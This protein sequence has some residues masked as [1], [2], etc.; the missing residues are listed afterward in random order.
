[1][2]MAVEPSVDPRKNLRGSCG[3]AKGDFDISHAQLH[4]HGA[5]RSAEP[6]SAI[7]T[8][9]QE[10]QLCCSSCSH[11]PLNTYLQVDGVKQFTHRKINSLYGRSEDRE[12]R[13]SLK[14]KMIISYADVQGYCSLMS[15][16]EVS[17][18]ERL[19]CAI[20]DMSEL[21]SSRGGKVVDTSGDG[22]MSVFDDPSEAVK[23]AIEFQRKSFDWRNGSKHEKKMD[24][25]IGINVGNV[26]IRKNGIHGHH[27]NIAARIQEYAMPGG[28]IISDSVR[29]KI[30]PDFKYSNFVS[31]GA[32]SLKNIETPV[33]VHEV[34][35]WI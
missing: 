3:C 31:L 19:L 26:F 21:A 24:F 20:D 22:I 34:C 25:R 9:R 33:D 7:A 8:V 4:V 13:T 30:V 15:Q 5:P 11:L 32:F 2:T 29:R 17:T 27:V 12:D 14:Q 23:F 1:M 6:R 28:V 10:G 35:F 16:D 18:I